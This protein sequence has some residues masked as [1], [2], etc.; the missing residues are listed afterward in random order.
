MVFHL[1][2]TRI[3]FTSAYVGGQGA[4]VGSQRLQSEAGAVLWVASG[5]LLLSV[6]MQTEELGLS[7]FKCF[8]FALFHCVQPGER[9]SAC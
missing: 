7:Y 2:P 1:E 5:F 3:L 8:V 4:I 6:G 9:G